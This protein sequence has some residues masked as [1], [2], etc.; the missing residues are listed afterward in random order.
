MQNCVGQDIDS[1][2]VIFLL[3]VRTLRYIF[4]HICINAFPNQNSFASHMADRTNWLG[5]PAI[6]LLKRQDADSKV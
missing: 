5:S 3:H 4:K 6:R 2:A 1:E